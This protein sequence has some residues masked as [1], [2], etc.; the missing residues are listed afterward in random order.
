[1]VLPLVPLTALVA[2]FLIRKALQE[3]TDEIAKS[4]RDEAWLTG[5]GAASRSQLVLKMLL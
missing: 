5:K 1:M 4:S 3:E 2:L